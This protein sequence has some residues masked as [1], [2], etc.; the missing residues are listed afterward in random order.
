MK[1]FL[2]KHKGYKTSARNLRVEMKTT[3]GDKNLLVGIYFWRKKDALQYIRSK[4]EL[5]EKCSEVISAEA[6]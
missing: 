6:N 4:G 1:V 2:V 3:I 5:Y